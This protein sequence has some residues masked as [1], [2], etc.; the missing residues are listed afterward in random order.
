MQQLFDKMRVMWPVSILTPSTKYSSVHAPISAMKDD[1]RREVAPTASAIA[2]SSFSA[3]AS[4]QI[5]P[6][7]ISEYSSAHP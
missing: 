2:A 7:S 4:L 5:T 6:S 1:S 3:G